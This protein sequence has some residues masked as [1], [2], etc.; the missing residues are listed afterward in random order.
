MCFEERSIA[1]FCFLFNPLFAGN[2]VKKQ[3][4]LLRLKK[5]NTIKEQSNG[6]H[7][8]FRKTSIQEII[9]KLLYIRKLGL[10]FLQGREFFYMGSA[11]H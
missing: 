10:N 3:E 2:W 4:K 7:K 6:K 9:F 1:N 11:Q 8:N 5:T